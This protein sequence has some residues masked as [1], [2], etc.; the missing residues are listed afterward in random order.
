MKEKEINWIPLEGNQKLYESTVL[1]NGDTLV[2]FDTGEF[3]K[4]N[5]ENWPMAVLTHFQEL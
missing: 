1:K 4:W 2:L 5:S 3:C